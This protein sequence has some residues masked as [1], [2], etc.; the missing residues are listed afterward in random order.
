VSPAVTAATSS[1]SPS[2]AIVDGTRQRPF[3]T[4]HHRPVTDDE[5]LFVNQNRGDD[6][7][8]PPE[9]PG[10]RRPR[11]AHP[12]GG[13]LLVE[14]LEVSETESLELVEREGLGLELARRTTDRFESPAHGQATYASR[15]GGSD[16]RASCC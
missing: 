11:Y 15:F 1:T 3:R 10:E 13:R 5:H 12:L 7:P 14:A 8:R 6:R 9:N 2:A 16:H 4:L